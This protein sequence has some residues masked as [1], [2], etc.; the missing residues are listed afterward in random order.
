MSGPINVGSARVLTITPSC[1]ASSLDAADVIFATE[2][3]PQVFRRDGGVV[4]LDSVVVLDLA[5]Q[6]TA[7]DLV[8][9]KTN[10]AVGTEDA[11]VTITDANS[12]E[13]LGVVNVL[14]ADF[15]DHIGSQVATL[16]NVGLIMQADGSS[17][18]IFVAGVS[19]SG[20]PTYGVSGLTIKI[21]VEDYG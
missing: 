3:I 18:S 4:K 6:G 16:H 17:S 21:A 7:I 20:T 9:L 14:A 1:E 15:D 19:R 10:V 12:A 2:E 11:G 13:I 5:D 8:F